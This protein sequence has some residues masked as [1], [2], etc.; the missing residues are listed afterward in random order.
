M[1]RQDHIAKIPDDPPSC[2][3]SGGDV[4]CD[5]V[6]L[7]AVTLLASACGDTASLPDTPARAVPHSGIAAGL[8]PCTS[9]PAVIQAALSSGFT[10]LAS[11][12]TATSTWNAIVQ[13]T[14]ANN[15]TLAKAKAFEL[16]DFLLLQDSL[17]LV[18]HSPA[19]LATLMNQVFCY[20]GIDAGI[21]NPGRPGWCTSAIRSRR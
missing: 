1:T 19:A 17:H 5:L 14:N 6:P 3:S 7:L 15:P 13:A 21:A 18:A 16:V 2:I 4:S 12:F 8:S 11:T 10:S 20:V 9:D